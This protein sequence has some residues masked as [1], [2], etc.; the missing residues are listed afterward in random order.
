MAEKVGVAISMSAIGERR[1]GREEA[2][3]RRKM[4]RLALAVSISADD[5][6]ATC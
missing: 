4:W 2:E 6:E 1:R 3:N 5:R